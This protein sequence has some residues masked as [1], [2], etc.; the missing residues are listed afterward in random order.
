MHPGL[1]RSDKVVLA[2][3]LGSATVETRT[4]M[5]ELAVE[6]VVQVLQGKPPT[7]PIAGTV[8]MT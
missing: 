7:T 4:R 1:L 8:T 3:H 6:N 2:P 5:A